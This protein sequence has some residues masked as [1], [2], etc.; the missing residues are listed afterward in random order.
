MKKSEIFNLWISKGI[1][2]TSIEQILSKITGLSLKQLFLI[3]EIDDKYLNT[4]VIEFERIKEWVPIEY[5]L[6]EAFF[7]SLSFFV[8]K[9]VLIPRDDTEVL[10]EEAIKEI[11]KVEENTTTIDIWTWSG[12]IPI[13]IIK[14]CEKKVENCYAVDISQ[15]ALEVAKINIKK[16]WL[17]KKITTINWSLLESLLNTS[18]YIFKY[19]V[20]ITA[21]LPY[22]KNDDF[23]NMD[24]S[25]YINEPN[26]ALFW[27]KVNGFE[28]YEELIDQI[29]E[30]IS[31]HEIKVTLFIEIWF[32]QKLYSKKYL[33]E[34]KLKHKFFK[35]NNL[36]NRCIKIE[37]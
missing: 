26:L 14:T 8:D 16:Y 29:K 10:V 34:E 7:H 9:R 11:Q 2:I 12:C 31:L 17:E 20:I 18:K 5:I 32:D 30:L 36:I 28:L 27:W 13:S 3:N 35:D 19:N 22:I 1:V 37:F 15:K 4:I 24:N 6:E 33:T 23:E 21:N 25:V